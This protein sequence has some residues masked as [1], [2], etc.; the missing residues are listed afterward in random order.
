V[1]SF[2]SYGPAADGRVKPDIASVG[3]NTVIAISGEARNGTSYACPNMA[4][5]A[6]C[7]WQGFREF[8]NITIM[9]ALRQAGSKAASP[10]NRVGYG[11]PDV[12]KAVL[13]L[14][15]NF[16]TAT[17]SPSGSCR[18]AL[19]W[20]SK[21]V[22]SMV[23]EIERRGAGET[24]YKKIGT[25][26]GTGTVFQAQSYQFIDSSLNLSPGT[27]TYRIR[28]VI[29]TA[30]ATFMAGYIDSV[31]INYSQSCNIT[32]IG[33]VPALGIAAQLLPNPATDQIQLRLT[34]AVAIPRLYLR[35]M[36]GKGSIVWQQQ[37]AKSSGTAIITI[38]VQSFA[39]GTYY[40]SVFAGDKVFAH[41]KFMKL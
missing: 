7:L 26:Q 10:D 38:P 2:S 37:T 11:I 17:I 35:V 33:P 23:Y 14:L 1:A 19:N 25:Q 27:V 21:D 20:T 32:G 6:T 22:S 31:S 39:T 3:A 29:D 9:N 13:S 41:Q 18:H 4:G 16:S 36:D 34:T 24:A 5:L 40:L 30:A 8:N 28:Q 15:Q 12:K